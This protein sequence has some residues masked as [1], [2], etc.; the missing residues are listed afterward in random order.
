MIVTLTLKK[1]FD[2][3]VVRRFAMP[4]LN[5]LVYFCLERRHFSHKLHARVSFIIGSDIVA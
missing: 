5:I 1:E 2:E 4:E 3:K